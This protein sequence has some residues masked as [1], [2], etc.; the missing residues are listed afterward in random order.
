MC[1][2]TLVKATTTTTPRTDDIECLC[3]LLTTAGKELDSSTRDDHRRSMATCF[4]R[5]DK[6]RVHQDVDK[7][8]QFLIMVRLALQAQGECTHLVSMHLS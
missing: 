2:Q 1:I 6:L 4:D 3:K 8:L 5:L 7:R